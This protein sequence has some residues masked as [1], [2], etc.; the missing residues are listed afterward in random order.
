MRDAGPEARA[1]RVARQAASWWLVTDAH[2]QNPAALCSRV[3]PNSNVMR[4]HAIEGRPDFSRQSWSREERAL[5]DDPVKL[6]A[7]ADRA[8]IARFADPERAA[9]YACKE[10]EARNLL[11]NGNA[12]QPEL[13]PLEAEAR[14]LPVRQLAALVIGRANADRAALARAWGRSEARRVRD[15]RNGDEE[16]MANIRQKGD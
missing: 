5:V 12:P 8:I 7:I 1:K 11:T 15:A 2:G 3:H 4:T 6:Q 14:G 13:L 9:I 16:R 10:A